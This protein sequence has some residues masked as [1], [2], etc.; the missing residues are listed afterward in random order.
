MARG[1]RFA[2]TIRHI[3]AAVVLSGGVG[4]LLAACSNSGTAL[5][6][7][8]CVHVHSSIRLYT[9]AEHATDTSVA[10][11]KAY[12]AIGQLEQAEQTAAQANS[13]NPAFNPLMT[14]LQEIGRTSEANLIPA[15]RAQ[16]AAANGSTAGSTPV[17]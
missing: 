6:Q 14:T 13:A 12:E 9:E 17:G 1:C 8:A 15:L 7:K 11:K 2:R 10:R 3:T 16:C 4:V 5:A